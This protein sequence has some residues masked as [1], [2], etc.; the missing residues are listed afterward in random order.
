MKWAEK[1]EKEK[2]KEEEEE[3]EKEEEEEEEE[4]SPRLRQEKV[5]E[6]RWVRHRNR[7]I[8]GEEFPAL[9]Q[10]SALEASGTWDR[11]E[12][13]SSYEDLDPS[14]CRSD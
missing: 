6:A 1:E 9:K 10:M 5:G 14:L 8:V 13:I 11:E 3:E 7:N 2:E 4:A 12:D